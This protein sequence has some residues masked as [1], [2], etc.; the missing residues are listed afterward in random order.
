MVEP[1]DENREAL[2]LLIK[3]FQYWL[4]IEDP[5]IIQFV[6]ALKV[7]H[8]LTSPENIMALLIGASSAGKSE[9][10]RAFLQ[11]GEIKI[12]DVTPKSFVSG[13]EDTEEKIPQLAAKLKDNIWYIPDLTCIQSRTAEDRAQ[14]LSDIR[15]IND[16]RISKAYGTKKTHDID[17]SHNTLIAAS[18]PAIDSTILQDQ[19]LG[20][21]W[22]PYRLETGNRF[23]IMGKIDETE[24]QLPV[25]RE[26][27]HV[28]TGMFEHS[29]KLFDFQPTQTEN[30]N[31]QI[32][33]NL[34]TTLRTSIELDRN[35]E[36][37]NLASIEGPAR[38]YKQLKKIYSAMRILGLTE[39]E[40]FNI[41]RKLCLDSVNPIRVKL[42]SWLHEHHNPKDPD[43]K[44][45]TSRIAHGCL[46]G[47]GPT[48]GHLGQLFALGLVDYEEVYNEVQHRIE[49]HWSYKAGNFD[50]LLGE[51]RQV[52]LPVAEE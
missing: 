20:T 36:V 6:A 52:K 38:M 3:N 42:F 17:T 51:Y 41:I 49:D 15:L 13:Y 18:T 12:D 10:L 46:L 21:R 7:S 39:E 24:Q 19:L 48:K 34:S 43:Q 2:N 35:H 8:K 26:A 45:T 11:S 44:F 37:R 16:G 29:I 30:Q 32:F 14:I 28:S 25:M 31:L 9:I 33:T 23:S 40:T 50:L 22:L 4:H 27:L 1:V 47:K 5:Q